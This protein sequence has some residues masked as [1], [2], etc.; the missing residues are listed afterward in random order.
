MHF[1]APPSSEV[2]YF[3]SARDISTGVVKL[4]PLGSAVYF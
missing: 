3:K 1:M 4:Y 2:W